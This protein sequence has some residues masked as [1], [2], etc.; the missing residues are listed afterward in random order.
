LPFSAVS[1]PEAR[2]SAPRARSLPRR[3]GWRLERSGDAVAAHA[4]TDGAQW[5]LVGS[6]TIA[7]AADVVVG[8]AVSS[9]TT[10]AAATATF[11]NVALTAAHGAS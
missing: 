5:T 3:T 11:T 9:H 6:D 2:A 4:S 1:P 8:I 7:M 10:T